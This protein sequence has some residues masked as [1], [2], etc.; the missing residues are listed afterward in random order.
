MMVH[1][2]FTFL[3]E[4]RLAATAALPIVLLPIKNQE[5]PV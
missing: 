3:C 4:D 2:A 5:N 1:I